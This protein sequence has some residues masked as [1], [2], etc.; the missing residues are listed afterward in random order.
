MMQ[1]TPTLWIWTDISRSLNPEKPIP[2]SFDLANLTAFDTNPLSQSSLLDEHS[3][4]SIARDATQLLVNQLLSLPR[5]RSL[6][7]AYIQLPAP[8]T[9]LPR[10]KSVHQPPFYT[11]FS[12]PNPN[13]QRNGS[14]S[15]RRRVFPKP[16]HRIRFIM[17]RLGNGFLDGDIKAQT[18]KRKMSGWWNYRP[19]VKVLRNLRKQKTLV[20]Q[21]NMIDGRG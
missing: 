20:Q 8:T 5:T 4:Q 17:R 10:E 14:C 9:P 18:K 2:L 1:R 11:D 15:P 16:R 12:Y 7:G 3:V 6:E 19:V 21:L 13:L